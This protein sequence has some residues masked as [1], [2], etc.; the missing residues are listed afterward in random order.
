MR[1]LWSFL[2]K[3]SR[4]G[5]LILVL[6]FIIGFIECYTMV[7][8]LEWTKEK[9]KIIYINI[10][11]AD[12][13][14]FMNAVWQVQ[15]SVAIL[16]ITFITLIIGRLDS[17]IFGFKLNEVLHLRKKISLNYWDKVWLNTGTVI[18]NF[19]YVSLGNISGVTLIFLI[20]SFLTLSLLRESLN[21]IRKPENYELEIESYIFQELEKS[22]VEDNK[23]IIQ[24]KLKEKSG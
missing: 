22:I 9:F 16:T 13:R 12:Y 3:N 8:N 17:K 19:F 11:V 21:I 10:L 20:S 7:L 14:S 6:I 15:T 24:K 4:L 5:L 2:K 1:K 18:L 23:T